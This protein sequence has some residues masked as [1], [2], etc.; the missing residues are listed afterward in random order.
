MFLVAYIMS[1][2]VA[3]LF[4]SRLNEQFLLGA[5]NQA[6]TTEY[7]AGLETVKSLQMEPQL[8]ARYSDY[9]AE[10]LRTG[11]SVR[12]KRHLQ[13]PR[14]DDDPAHLGRGRLYRDEEQRLHHR[15]AH[16]L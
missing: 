15:D 7:V 11:F 6:F 4:R 16:R 10:Y 12:Q 5:R 14:T 1:F 3:P 2:I 13:W 9:L 8:N